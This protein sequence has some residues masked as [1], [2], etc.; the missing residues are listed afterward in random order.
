[1]FM[2]YIISDND[3]GGEPYG[4]IY[5]PTLFGSAGGGP[6]GGAGG[7]RIWLNVTNTILI[8]GTLTASGDNG[9]TQNN[10]N[11]ISSP[12]PRVTL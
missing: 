6:K 1:M 11:S 7:G 12:S 5:E 9:V 3:Y 4:D 8:D 2:Y 10:Y